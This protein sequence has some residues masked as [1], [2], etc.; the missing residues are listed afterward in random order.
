MCLG[1]LL[2]HGRAGETAPAIAG[3]SWW[4]GDRGHLNHRTNHQASAARPRISDAVYGTSLAHLLGV[5]FASR[6]PIAVFLT[7]FDS[8]GTE[9]QMIELARRLDRRRFEVHVA[10]FHK[11]GAWL[12]RVESEVSGI[13]E[14][15]IRGFGNP[16]ALRRAGAFVRWCR[17]HR[18][19]VVQA[20]DIY[21][22][23]F[24]LPAARLAGVSVR[25]G[26][27]REVHPSRGRVLEALQ[28]FGY[29]QAD[30]VVANSEAGASRLRLEGVEERRIAVVRNGLDLAP[31]AIRASPRGRHRVVTVA[32]FRPEKAHEVLLAAI[33]RLRGDWPDVE[34]WLAG[35]GPREPALRAL[36]HELKIA[37]AVRFLGHRDDVPELLA[38]CDVFVLPSRIEAAP[39]AVLEAMASGLPVIA[40]RVGGVPEAITHGVNGIL[41]HPDDPD[42][43][44]GALGSLFA[45]PSSAERI[46]RAGRSHVESNYSFDRMVSSFEQLYL[47]ELARHG[48]ECQATG[49]D[50][51][52]L[53]TAVF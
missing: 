43:L 30:R 15:P 25:V 40:S 47:A 28:R 11:R 21:A 8:G 24:A 44:A 39:N 36:A 35:D 2:I 17:A 49:A 45:D 4:P 50:P 9:R 23:A 53:E 1:R 38:Q 20:A 42:A 32:R 27:R 22:N 18:I 6:I 34:V 52:D 33:S 41:V 51:G 19:A 46:G 48:Y 16:T 12:P 31:F 3:R 10:C 37:D 5:T 13:A 14:F 29:S 7:S 26:S